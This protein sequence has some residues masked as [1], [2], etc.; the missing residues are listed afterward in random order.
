M[1][2]QLLEK[3]RTQLKIKS[4]VPNDT[5]TKIY[6]IRTF[7]GE[8]W[9]DHYKREFPDDSV[10]TIKKIEN[11]VSEDMQSEE[12]KNVLDQIFSNEKDFPDNLKDVYK[13]FGAFKVIMAPKHRQWSNKRKV[14]QYLTIY[15]PNWED[16]W[17]FMKWRLKPDMVKLVEKYKKENPTIP[18]NTANEIFTNI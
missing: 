1:P 4:Y 5:L 9:K 8:N 2:D 11:Y 6:F 17:R 18:A 15:L 16:K 14:M 7:G 12:W 13:L 3:F 10:H